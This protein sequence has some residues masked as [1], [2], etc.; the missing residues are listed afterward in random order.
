MMA[1]KDALVSVEQEISKLTQATVVGNSGKHP[2]T[3][4]VTNA[5]MD[6]CIKA[7]DMI[8]GIPER[9]MR[10][11]ERAAK[12][13]E[14]LGEGFARS[15]T[16]LGDEFRESCHKAAEELRKLRAVTKEDAEITANKLTEVGSAEAAR[17]ANITEGIND[18]RSALGRIANIDEKP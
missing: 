15:L 16:Q 14:E 11:G 13:L 9:E 7:A 5:I 17:H 8:R 18:M 1:T 6:A 2:V 12:E 4:P 3:S 10:E